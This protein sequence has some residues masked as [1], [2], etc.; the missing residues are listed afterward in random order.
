MKRRNEG[1]MMNEK[2][3]TEKNERKKQIRFPK[4]CYTVYKK[5]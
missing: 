5:G 4:K 3:S 1:K 2:N